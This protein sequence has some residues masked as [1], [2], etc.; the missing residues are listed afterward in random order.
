MADPAKMLKQAAALYK[1]GD[2]AKAQEIL[3]NLVQIDE[4]NEKAWLLLSA[5]VDGLEDKQIA[6]E[7]V[8]TINPN[9]EKAQKGLE[10]VNKKLA[11]MPPKKKEEPLGGT[12]WSGINTEEEVEPADDGWGTYLDESSQS[13][14]PFTSSETSDPASPDMR[15][16]EDSG[17]GDLDASAVFTQAGGDTWGSS[18]P[19][20]PTPEPASPPPA[21]DEPVGA[22]WGDLDTNADPWA[23]NEGFGAP[24]PAWGETSTPEPAEESSPWGAEPDPSPSAFEDTSS[25]WGDTSLDIDEPSPWGDE[26]ASPPV[27]TP[28]ASS[29]PAAGQ[30]TSEDYDEWIGELNLKSDSSDTSAPASTSPWGA[31]DSSPWDEALPAQETQEPSPWAQDAEVIS[32]AW[33][34]WGTGETPAAQPATTEESPWGSSSGASTSASPFASADESPFGEMPVAEMANSTSLGFDDNPFDSPIDVS[35]SSQSSSASLSFGQDNPFADLLEDDDAD[36]DLLDNEEEIESLSDAISVNAG[37]EKRLSMASSGGQRSDTSK[38]WQMIPA[39]I[40]APTKG[41]GQLSAILT[42]I[43]LLVLNLGALGW[44]V[45]QLLG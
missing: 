23:N 4:N 13:Q 28:A 12:G 33:G 34:D 2:R 1:K 6:L 27:S 19:A 18:T 35:S 11:Q 42:V 43:V 29:T 17:W 30:P 40:K 15:E 21:D 3:L 38:Y 44:L 25:G 41:G 22:S 32:D 45:S 20:A 8:L 24:D 39:E 26:P 16:E 36:F 5:A 37:R 9:N 14:S 31:D 10:L 7:N